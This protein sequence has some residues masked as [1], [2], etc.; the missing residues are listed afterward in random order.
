MLQQAKHKLTLKGHLHGV[1]SIAFSPDGSVLA[2]GSTGERD[3]LEI[4]GARIIMWDTAT[5]EQIHTLTTESQVNALVFSS[6]GKML[7]S[8]EDWPHYAI[9]LW[10]TATGTQ[11]YTLT[12]RP[13]PNVYKPFIQNVVFFAAGNMLISKSIDDTIS[14]YDIDKL[15]LNRIFTELTEETFCATLSSDQQTLA[16]GNIK[17]SIQLWDMATG[18]LKQSIAVS[19]T[20]KH[21]AFSPDDRALT[22]SMFGDTIYVLDAATGDSKHILS[23]FN[24]PIKSIAFNPDKNT[25]AIPNN[26]N[27]E[28]WD[29]ATNVHKHTL[30]GHIRHINSIVFS[31][32]K[33]IIASGSADSTIRFWDVNIGTH[34]RTLEGIYGH[35]GPVTDIAFSP[36]G[37]TLASGSADNTIC[38]WDVNTGKRKG[39]MSTR[40]GDGNSVVFSNDGKTLVSGGEV[41]HRGEDHSFG[42][43]GVLLWNVRTG[44]YK[45]EL[46]GKMGDVNCVAFSPDGRTLAS[47]EGWADYAIRL[48]DID[49]NKLNHALK[50]HTGDVYSVDFSP[51]GT[52]LASGSADN[53]IRLWDVATRKHLHTLTGHTGDVNSIV[54][55]ADGNLLI[56]G[57][58]DGTVLLWDLTSTITKHQP[59]Q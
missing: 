34:I 58:D 51:D 12:G 46:K 15:R 50:G 18:K 31:P 9:R 11:T 25:L 33:N 22:I 2:S 29:I 3:G 47:G 57:S 8:G 41:K 59:I 56:S 5:G 38:L 20:P 43:K 52:I 35:S 37:K 27:I 10:D 54:F 14:V 49:M 7:A 44:R 55:S 30:T 28:L 53:T 36:D 48:W 39:N 4:F 17:K 40:I 23:G 1:S 21:I 16:T 24:Q 13:T 26:V 42:Y 45:Y 19:R 32:D 6:N